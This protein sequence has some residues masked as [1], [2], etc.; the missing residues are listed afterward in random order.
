MQF[1]PVI[2]LFKKNKSSSLLFNAGIILG[3]VLG[4]LIGLV[5]LSLLCC[6]CVPSICT[7]CCAFISCPIRTR[8]PAPKAIIPAYRPTAIYRPSTGPC[9]T[10]VTTVIA[11][12][13]LKLCI[14]RKYCGYNGGICNRSFRCPRSVRC[15]G[16]VRRY[17]SQ[18]ARPYYGCR[19]CHY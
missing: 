6:F 17:H 9:T 15:H 14:P 18:Y 10:N 2:S 11:D 13:N 7:N 4:G 5:L 19:P 16:A 12:N 3:G 8:L 1:Q